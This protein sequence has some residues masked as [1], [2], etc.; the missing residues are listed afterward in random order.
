M[1]S[2][3]IHSQENYIWTDNPKFLQEIQKKIS[4]DIDQIRNVANTY[5]NC[6]LEVLQDV[7]PKKI[8]YFLI[9]ASEKSFSHMLYD[10]VKSQNIS[11][12]LQEYDEIHIQRQTLDKTIK[13]LQTSKQMIESIL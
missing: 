8:V 10:K 13:E 4:T 12:L 1:I 3:E 11:T 9:Q 7:I 6:I 2:H 5:Y